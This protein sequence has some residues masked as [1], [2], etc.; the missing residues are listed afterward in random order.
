[1][2]LGCSHHFPFSHHIHS[3]FDYRV[4]PCGTGHE[5]AGEGREENRGGQIGRELK[6]LLIMGRPG[7]GKTTLIRTVVGR[8]TIERA[9]GFFTREVRKT[10]ERTGFKIETLDGKAGVLASVFADDGP[11]VGKYRVNLKDLERIGVAGIEQGLEG[12]DLIV[13]DE[14]GKMELF[15]RRFRDVVKNAFDSDAKVLA[16]VKIGRQGFIRDLVEREDT[17][18]LM[19]T[20]ANRDLVANAALDFVEG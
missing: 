1:M 10:G 12:C 9:A 8:S 16:T 19:L 14:I 20:E 15:S 5:E 18:V 13:I 3:R 17:K 7:V 11:R 6:N 4:D 2:A